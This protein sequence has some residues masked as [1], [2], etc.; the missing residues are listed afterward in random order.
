M[1]LS[2]TIISNPA[3]SQPTNSTLKFDPAKCQIAGSNPWEITRNALIDRSD[4]APTTPSPDENMCKLIAWK[5]F[6]T[7]QS[8]YAWES[9]EV[10]LNPQVY[11]W[12]SW[13]LKDS[14]PHNCAVYTSSQDAGSPPTKPIYNEYYSARDGI[15]LHYES[16]TLLM[17]T[18]NMFRTPE[19]EFREGEVSLFEF[20][21][22]NP[23]T[24]TAL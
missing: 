13:Q 9:P 10:T 6:T 16:A 2:N 4:T 22:Y 24:V 3:A 1:A 8:Q 17:V 11:Y 14:I 20:A 15:V 12:L 19:R 18:V 21:Y 7:T 23:L 5:R